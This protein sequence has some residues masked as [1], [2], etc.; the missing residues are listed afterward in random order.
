MKR[1]WTKCVNKYILQHLKNYNLLTIR[2]HEYFLVESI[3]EILKL[4]IANK[5]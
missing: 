2:V 5:Y 4:K 1:K 3:S